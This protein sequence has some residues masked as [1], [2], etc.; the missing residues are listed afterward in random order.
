MTK[1][2]NPIPYKL[3]AWIGRQKAM[4]DI[5]RTSKN[6]ITLIEIRRRQ[7]EEQEDMMDWAAAG[8]DLDLMMDGEID[9]EYA[10][11]DR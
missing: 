10:K 1:K 11:G 4:Q 6:D 5:R 7:R 8:F 9:N 3:V 2:N